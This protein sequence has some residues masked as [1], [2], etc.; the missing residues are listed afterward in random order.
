MEELAQQAAEAEVIR[1]AAD[2]RDAWKVYTAIALVTLREGLEAVVFLAGVGDDK[3][4]AIPLPA[5]I[6]ILLGVIAGMFLFYSGRLVQD[7]KGFFVGMTILLL[8]LAAGQIANGVGA[9]AEGHALGGPTEEEIEDEG[10]PPI[11]YLRPLWSTAECCGEDADENKF[12]AL[13]HAIFGYQDKGTALC[14]ILYFGYWLIVIG[15][16]IFKWR[17]GTLFDADYKYTQ[18]EKRR[19]EEEMAAAR[20]AALDGTEIMPLPELKTVLAGKEAEMMQSAPSSDAQ[21][22]LMAKYEPPAPEYKRH[23]SPV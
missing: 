10:V 22:T 1:R 20:A 8:F 7:M 4:T 5:F 6:G 13:L 21:T 23:D 15:V 14:I 17:K 18:A 9:L 19:V 12:F 3:P 11:W 16:F 2:R